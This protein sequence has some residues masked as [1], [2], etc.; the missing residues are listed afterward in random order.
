MTKS[1]AARNFTALLHSRS[2]KRKSATL[3]IFNIGS[4]N[5]RI[6]LLNL[7][8]NCPYACG[9]ATCGCSIYID[10][11]AKSAQDES[12]ICSYTCGKSTA[13]AVLKLSTVNAIIQPGKKLH[14]MVCLDC[15]PLGAASLG[16][17]SLGKWQPTL[18]GHLCSLGVGASFSTK[19][20]FDDRFYPVLFCAAG[21]AQSIV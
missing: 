15:A 8:N 4:E 11:G 7:R 19:N 14:T 10:L 6:A 2:R 1:V 21:E 18:C 13:I 17:K 20:T 12:A 3:S 5:K 9:V 16:T